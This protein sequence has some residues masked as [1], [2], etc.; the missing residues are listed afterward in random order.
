MR[1]LLQLFDENLQHKNVK[2]QRILNFPG[3]IRLNEVIKIRPLCIN[4]LK[5]LKIIR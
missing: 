5:L 2:E 3:K 4:V 1:R